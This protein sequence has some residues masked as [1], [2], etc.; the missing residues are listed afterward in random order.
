M[1]QT[2][3]CNKHNMAELNDDVLLCVFEHCDIDTFLHLRLL[4]RSILKLINRNIDALSQKVAHATFPRQQDIFASSQPPI[5]HDVNWLKYLRFK[6]LAAI[7]VECTNQNNNGNNLLN[8]DN[9]RGDAPR[10]QIFVAFRILSSLQHVAFDVS[11]TPDHELL[12]N[13][14]FSIPDVPVGVRRHFEK[15]GLDGKPD[16]K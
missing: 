5:T 13:V 4:S 6:Q 10:M 11:T 12:A 15:R 2:S 16:G 3:S 1:V 7:L 14:E 8:A 9:P